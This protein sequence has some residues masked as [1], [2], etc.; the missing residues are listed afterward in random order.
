MYRRLLCLW[1]PLAL[2]C[3][4]AQRAADA[5]AQGPAAAPR[6]ALES[7][8]AVVAAVRFAHSLDDSLAAHRSSF[9]SREDVYRHYRRGFADEI[10]G[11]LADH[12]W[13][14]GLGELRGTEMVLEAPDSVVVLRVGPE[15]AEAAYVT[16]PTDRA[17]GRGPYT[18]DRLR[19]AGGRWTIAESRDTAAR[20][21]GLPPPPT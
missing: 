13:D 2:G 1:L 14:A 7:R 5:P 3:D 8:A 12:A 20:L 21:P 10:A 9:R 19:R 4:R 15:E 17:W 6:P 18:I 11:R 16:P